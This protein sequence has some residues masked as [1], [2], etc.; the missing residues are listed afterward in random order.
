MIYIFI[1]GKLVYALPN[2]AEVKKYATTNLE[3]LW[4]EYKRN[5][6][7]EP[8]P[9]DLSKICYDHKMANIELARKQVKEQEAYFNK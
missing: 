6:N 7:P 1:N 5:L 8:Y 2:L 4:D 9:V 3:S